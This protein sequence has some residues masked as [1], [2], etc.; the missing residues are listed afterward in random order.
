MRCDSELDVS[1]LV[2]V[3][4][5]SNVPYPGIRDYLDRKEKVGV[6]EYEGGCLGQ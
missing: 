5:P 4:V 1:R 3:D 2:A 6:L